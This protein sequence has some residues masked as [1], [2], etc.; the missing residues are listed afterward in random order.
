MDIL[1]AKENII[2]QQVNCCKVM[3]AGLA[4]AIRNKYPKVYTEYRNRDGKLGNVLLV[5]VEDNKWV[6]NIYGQQTYGRNKNVVYTDYNAVETALNKVNKFATENN[7]S[8]AV[9]YKMGCGLANG[10]WNK[11]QEIL[12][13]T[14]T[15]YT[16]YKK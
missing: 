2:V 3:G 13:K 12:N 8:I 16:I 7:L 11:I 6:A 4:L 9:P 1:E 10:N 5:K 15:N 14:L